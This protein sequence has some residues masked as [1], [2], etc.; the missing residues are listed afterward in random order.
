MKDTGAFQDADQVQ[1]AIRI[2]VIDLGADF[3]DA[4]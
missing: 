4:V 1:S 2:I 3:G